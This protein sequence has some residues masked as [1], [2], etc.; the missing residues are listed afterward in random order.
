MTAQPSQSQLQA[1]IDQASK[2]TVN[3]I[4]RIDACHK[5]GHINDPEAL[6]ALVAALDDPE[7]AVRWAAAE[8]L[9]RQGSRGAEAVLQALT[10]RYSQYLYTGA[11]HVL[12]HTIGHVPSSIVQPVIDA[13]EG[14]GAP[15]VTP[16]AARDALS[17]LHNYQRSKFGG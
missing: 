7:F 3:E 10:H 13:L 9:V 15:M 2:L 12:K 8:A 16:P 17:A 4:D 5:L 11:H 14:P 6:R 1:L